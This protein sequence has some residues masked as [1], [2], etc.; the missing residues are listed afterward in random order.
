MWYFLG[1]F[2][3]GAGSITAIYRLHI[4]PGW[5]AAVDRAE[6]EARRLR[7]SLFRSSL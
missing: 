7:G 3:L 4:I 6:V 2:F 5:K 1:G